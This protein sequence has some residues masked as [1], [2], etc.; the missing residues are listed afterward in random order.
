MN[1]HKCIHGVGFKKHVTQAF[2]E[3]QK[4]AMEMGTPDV[5]TDQV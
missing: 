4:P 2:K 1:I 5:R 3:T